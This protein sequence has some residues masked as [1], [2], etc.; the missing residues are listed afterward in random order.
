MARLFTT[1]GGQLKPDTKPTTFTTLSKEK[2]TPPK[3]VF[4]TTAL[5]WIHSLVD[6]HSQ[7]VGWYAIVD[8]RPEYTFF[9]RDV[10]Y[11]KH[12]EAN[13]GTCEISTDGE[14]DMANWL[15][16]NNRLDDIEKVRLWGHSHHTMG[17]GASGQDESQALD[18][19]TSTQSF[20]IRIICNKS[21]E[22]SCSFFD[23][24]NQVRFDHIKWTVEDDTPSHWEEAKATDIASVMSGDLSTKKKLKA[25]REISEKE[26]EIDWIREK[27]TALKKVNIPVSQY[28]GINYS[29]S[30]RT[31]K[32]DVAIA[33]S[34]HAGGN[35]PGNKNQESLFLRDP[36]HKSEK[37]SVN[38]LESGLQRNLD[39]DPDQDILSDIE[40]KSM[41]ADFDR[42]YIKTE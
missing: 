9:I 28:V 37:E 12:S 13:G 11:P 42:D 22:I 8:E 39:G 40:V 24:D 32:N 31:N 29:G 33:N 4:G 1:T 14:S 27:V 34:T 36:S 3:I 25:I 15:M 2:K 5:K 26:Y 19:M 21:G 10:F 6:I 7:E 17:T 35:M 16:D 41:I 23:W 30:H 18:R 20:L 38:E